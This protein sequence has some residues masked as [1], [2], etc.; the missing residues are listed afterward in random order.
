[1]FTHEERQHFLELPSAAQRLELLTSSL[2]NVTERRR[3][4]QQL[5]TVLKTK[6]DL[7]Y[8]FN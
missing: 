2:K 7:S 3:V 1:V 8:L 6:G 4:L 5:Q